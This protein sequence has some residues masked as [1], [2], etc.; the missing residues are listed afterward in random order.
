M[1]SVSQIHLRYSKTL[2]NIGEVLLYEPE[3]TVGYTSG[4]LYANLVAERWQI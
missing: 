2:P 3:A 1:I 4:A